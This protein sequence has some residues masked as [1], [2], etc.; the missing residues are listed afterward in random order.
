MTFITQFAT[1]AITCIRWI[2]ANGIVFL[3]RVVE[4]IIYVTR[5]MLNELAC[6]V[7]PMLNVLLL[8]ESPF[9]FKRVARNRIA[10][11]T[12]AAAT[13]ARRICCGLYCW[14]GI[15]LIDTLVSI[16]ACHQFLKKKYDS[17]FSLGI[18]LLKICRSDEPKQCI[19]NITQWTNSIINYI[20]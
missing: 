11:I 9:F 2:A 17:S 16:S 20:L 15:N 12:R 13:C 5:V 1:N 14:K 18:V 6:M 7:S 19:S 10:C 8:I 4:I 3:I